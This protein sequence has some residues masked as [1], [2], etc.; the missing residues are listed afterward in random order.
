MK[1]NNDGLILFILN[2]IILMIFFNT[3][4]TIQSRPDYQVSESDM[5]DIHYYLKTISEEVTS[6]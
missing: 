6:D 3:L 5:V 4:A 2:M 1:N